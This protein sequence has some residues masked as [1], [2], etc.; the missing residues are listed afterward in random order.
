MEHGIHLGVKTNGILEKM[1]QV[2]F[3]AMIVI[4]FIA[5]RR[6]SKR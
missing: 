6:H 1:E 5:N 3:K 2:I 4:E